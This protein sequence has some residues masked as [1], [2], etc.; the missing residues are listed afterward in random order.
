M[1][2]PWAVAPRRHDPREPLPKLDGRAWLERLGSQ[3]ARL[4]SQVEALRDQMPAALGGPLP[5]SAAPL[6]SLLGLKSPADAPRQV[7][8]TP[9][10]RLQFELLWNAHRA[11]GAN[12]RGG[13][14]AMNKQSGT[15]ELVNPGVST[16]G[17]HYAPDL[18][19]DGSRQVVGVFH[20]HFDK[21]FVQ[22]DASNPL[23]LSNTAPGGGDFAWA[24]EHN[25]DVNVVHAA[26]KDFM[27]VRTSQT[28]SLS[29]ADATK[30]RADYQAE[31]D[32]A[33]RP[34]RFVMSNEVVTQRLA[35]D[36]AAKYHLAYY[37]GTDG[38][39]TRVMPPAPAQP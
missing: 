37:E 33:I 14:L 30:L 31:L 8:V 12:E 27:F 13:T 19:V 10:L 34:G 26:S 32:S 28:P 21:D 7:A 39:F 3:F 2:D 20:T 38:V 24:L 16:L 23:G 5:I 36:Y 11:E 6:T 18:N 4:A 35:R 9:Q 1:G 17:N 22:K 29:T 15:I 25:T